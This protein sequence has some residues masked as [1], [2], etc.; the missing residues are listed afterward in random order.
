MSGDGTRGWLGRILAQPNDSREKTL[1][2]ALSNHTTAPA[3]AIAMQ[4]VG[5]KHA[6]QLNPSHNNIRISW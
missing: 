2:V 3:M 5:A 4:H 6:A 1:F